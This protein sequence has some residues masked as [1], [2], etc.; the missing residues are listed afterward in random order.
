MSKPSNLKDL[1]AAGH[2]SKAE[3]RAIARTM[4]DG[5]TTAAGPEGYVIT[6]ADFDA[7]DERLQQYVIKVLLE[8]PVENVLDAAEDEEDDGLRS[9]MEEGY[10]KGIG[11]DAAEDGAGEAE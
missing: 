8:F 10:R 7:L 1:L 3:I 5:E 6:A 9:G 2:I 11:L 4:F